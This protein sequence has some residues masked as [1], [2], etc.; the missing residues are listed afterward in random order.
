MDLSYAPQTGMLVP[1]TGLAAAKNRINCFRERAFSE[2]ISCDLV[3]LVGKFSRDLKTAGEIIIR[4]HD[5]WIS[6][7]Q[8]VAGEVRILISMVAGAKRCTAPEVMRAES[9]GPNA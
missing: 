7:S 2:P 5:V 6:V 8:Q 4:I 1:I 9:C 3:D